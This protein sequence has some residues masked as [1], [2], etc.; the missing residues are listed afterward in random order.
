MDSNQNTKR[1]ELEESL[2]GQRVL[3]ENALRI[4]AE[5]V[6][7]TITED[8]FIHIG[9]QITPSVYDDIIE[10]RSIEKI[11]GYPVCCNALTNTKKQKYYLSLKDKAVYDITVRKCF[12]SD[13]CFCASKHFRSQISITPL[14]LRHKEP[15]VKFTLL[16]RHKKT[17][18]GDLVCRGT[19]S[20]IVDE[21]QMLEQV[22]SL[23][24]NNSSHSTSA[25]PHDN[26]KMTKSTTIKQTRAAESP[27]CQQDGVTVPGSDY[28][29]NSD[30][31]L[32]QSEELPVSV[33]KDSCSESVKECQPQQHK[34][35]TGS[36][37]DSV[38]T[39]EECVKVEQG[40]KYERLS[41]MIEV[42]Q[43]QH[44]NELKES[45]GESAVADSS[46]MKHLQKLLG[47]RKTGQ[48]VKFIDDVPISSEASTDK[49]LSEVDPKYCHEIRNH[50]NN[51]A[52]RKDCGISHSN[53]LPNH[54]GTHEKVKVDV[55]QRLRSIVVEWVSVKTAHFLHDL[56]CD[57]ESEEKTSGKD[58]SS[59]AIRCETE[60]GEATK[61][62]PEMTQLT[63][64]ARNFDLKVR[65]F[66][67]QRPCDGDV[68]E[69][70]DNEK[71]IILPPVD[72]HSQMSLR[73]KIVLDKLNR[74]LPDVLT[75]LAVSVLDIR[76][77]VRLLVQTFVLTSKNILLKPDE[78]LLMA[79]ILLHML[80]MKRQDVHDAMK[81]ESFISYLHHSRPFST[82]MDLSTIKDITSQALAS[83]TS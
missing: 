74:V 14:W 63:E 13:Y 26:T 2:K 37:A 48:L 55:V 45:H 59:N 24:I 1:K 47:Q 80:A 60:S 53:A 65:E 75:H 9:Q 81:D 76:A 17:S 32:S 18:P 30:T 5:L 6:Y 58:P 50:T 10:E 83:F 79:V 16:E 54:C 28:T 66:Y 42:E 77:D 73:R 4:V 43:R 3:E 7:K 11:C 15:P 61:S 56:S 8:Q 31:T 57:N 72:S 71:V 67:G 27:S 52:V 49:T 20:D 70:E 41:E 82:L 44:S 39:D 23:N 19:L 51:F 64:D 36:E 78:W 62:L 40:C 29:L 35:N 46:N 69:K 38:Q 25:S 22:E 21:V 33:K 12:C 34:L 68:I